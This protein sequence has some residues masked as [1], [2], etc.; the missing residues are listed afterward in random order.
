[1]SYETLK[2]RVEKIEGKLDHRQAPLVIMLS[3]IIDS[4]GSEIYA[5]TYVCDGLPGMT[6]IRNPGEG[7]EDLL[8]RAEA[9]FLEAARGRLLSLVIHPA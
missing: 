6:V 1:M 2:R 3:P 8:G 9:E 7:D 5:D 4:D